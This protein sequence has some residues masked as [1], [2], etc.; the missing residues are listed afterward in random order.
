MGLKE[1]DMF[2]FVSSRTV[3]N[4]GGNSRPSPGAVCLV[5]Q[6]VYTGGTN[7]DPRL[8]TRHDKMSIY[9]GHGACNNS[10]AKEE[11]IVKVHDVILSA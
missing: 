7:W 11:V 4:D 8:V 9:L 1:N 5:Q 2:P 6:L 3:S 10:W